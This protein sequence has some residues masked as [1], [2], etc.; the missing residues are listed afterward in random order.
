MLDLPISVSV[1]HLQGREDAGFQ[2]WKRL[3]MELGGVIPVFEKW[4]CHWVL[5][6]FL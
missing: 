3:Q 1:R 5:M 2:E 6:G 4:G